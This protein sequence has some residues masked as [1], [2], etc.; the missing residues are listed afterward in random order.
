MEA[1]RGAQAYLNY[2]AWAV[3]LA[4]GF[5]ILRNFAAVLNR[6]RLGLWVILAG[7]PMNGI[8]D[9]GLVL[10][11]LGLPRMEIA[12]AGLASLIT[13]SVMFLTMLAI[14][15]R[16]RPLSRYNILG[17]FWK[18]DWPVFGQIFVLGLS[19]AGIMFLE[20]GLIM[21]SLMMIGWIGANA[22]AAHQIALML[23][24]VT[25]KV[26]LGISQAATVRV[27]HAAGRRDLKGVARAGWTAI[28]M[29]VAFMAMTSV[30]M[31]ICPE[32]LVAIFLDRA[33]AG[34]AAVMALAASLIMVA[35]V[36][37]IGDGVQTI[38]AGVL[39]GLSDTRVPMA[40]AAFG[41]W[42]LGLSSGYVLGLRMNLGT[43]G[44]WAGMTVGLTVVAIFYAVRFRHLVRK[45]HLPEVARD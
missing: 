6:P 20:F 13:H 21:G 35:A 36:F 19:I 12:G 10:G 38:G 33:D 9:Y 42:V 24:S 14:A 4:V 34:N 27:G 23:A 44:I 37:Q 26:P 39:R 3:T 28:A 5:L 22:L 18:P 8:L 32:L 45:G 43:V 41:F 29:G 31:W 11:H 15:L 2:Q 1:V 40:F 30:V 16:V 7:I 17:R 25:F